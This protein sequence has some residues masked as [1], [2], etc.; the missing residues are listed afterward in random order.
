LNKRKRYPCTF[1][2]ACHVHYAV[3]VLGWTQTQTAVDLGLNQGVVCHIV[4]GRRFPGS[5]PVP[6][7]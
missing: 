7:N 3:R 6:M 4:H 5:F 1:K 2:L